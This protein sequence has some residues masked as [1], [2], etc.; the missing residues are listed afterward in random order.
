MSKVKSE[1]NDLDKYKN[2]IG[3]IS[4]YKKNTMLLHNPYGAAYITINGYKEYWIEGKIHR[5]DG[6]AIIHSDGQEI[7]VINN[8]EFSKEE[9]EYHPERLK[10]L[11]KEHLICL[12]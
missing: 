6:P 11:N 2:I 8:K 3:C 4:Y 12:K 1:Y 7:Y 9:F 10:F 5:L